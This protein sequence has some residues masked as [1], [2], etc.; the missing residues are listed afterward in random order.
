MGLD[1]Y[2]GSLTRYYAG[3]WETVIQR[4]AREQG[5]ACQVIRPG[6]TDDGKRPPPSEV[7]ELVLLWRSKLNEALAEAEQAAL[8]WNESIEAPYFTDKP[9]WDC[10]GALC[11]WAAY[12]EHP[13]LQ[14]PEKTPDS[15]SEDAA[16]KASN[17]V[18]FQS[19]YPNLV[20]G[21]E[22]WLPC[23]FDFGFQAMGPAGQP[24]QFG[25]SVRLMEELAELN[26]RTWRADDE[27]IRDWRREC[28]DCE[29]APLETKAQFGYTILRH[30]ASQSVEH[31]LPM[32]LDY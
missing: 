17:A 16:Y 13:D 7:Q 6:G 8:T 11:L 32:K 3:D 14:R 30:L 21:V 28:P 27:T 19:G 5:I 2:V 18:D 29:K 23:E 4:A 9:A 26:E 24:M 22:L 25:S 20:R 12:D 15:F 1:I 31:N 10:Y